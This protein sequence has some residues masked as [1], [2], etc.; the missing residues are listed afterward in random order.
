MPCAN[1]CRNSF[2]VDYLQQ[3]STLLWWEYILSI[4]SLTQSGFKNDEGTFTFST[5]NVAVKL[6]GLF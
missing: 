1:G 2:L 3:L 5:C 6:D 4:L